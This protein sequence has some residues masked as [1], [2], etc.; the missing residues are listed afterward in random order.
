MKT[1]GQIGGEDQC[2]LVGHGVIDSYDMQEP[3][4]KIMIMHRQ[5]NGATLLPLAVIDSQ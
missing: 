2:L 3:R 4:S 1:K 5:T